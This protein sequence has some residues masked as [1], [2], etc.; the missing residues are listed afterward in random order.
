M[1]IIAEKKIV[2]QIWKYFDIISANIKY[3][4]LWTIFF[5]KY[6]KKMYI[7]SLREQYRASSFPSLPFLVEEVYQ[8]YYFNKIV[9][10]LNKYC[11]FRNRWYKWKEAGR[12]E[13]REGKGREGRGRGILHTTCEFNYAALR[14]W[15]SKKCQIFN[16]KICTLKKT[17]RNAVHKECIQTFFSLPTSLQ[18]TLTTCPPSSSPECWIEKFSTTNFGAGV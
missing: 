6:K 2:L 17:E 11:Y 10:Y 4:G 3:C 18:L 15:T 12:R 7:F 14:V 1:N 8:W 9:D 13:G 16:L 5:F